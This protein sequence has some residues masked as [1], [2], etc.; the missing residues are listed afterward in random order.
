MKEKIKKFGELN[1][2][3]ESNEFDPKELT[4]GEF[5]NMA[6]NDKLGKIIH[7]ELKY[8]IEDIK[9]AVARNSDFLNKK[10]INSKWDISSYENDNYVMIYYAGEFIIVFNE[11]KN[12]IDAIV[13]E[14]EISNPFVFGDVLIVPGHD[15]ITC[16]NKVTKETTTS[17]IR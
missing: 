8:L 7:Y 9:N 16:Y 6:K 12:G 4:W 17:Q 13:G 15:S 3:N 5:L 2:G 1:E 11:E 10:I 14:Y